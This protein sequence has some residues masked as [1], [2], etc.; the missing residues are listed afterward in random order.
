MRILLIGGGK[1]GSYLA[2]ELVEAGH[3]VSV[4]EPIAERAHEVT[5]ESKALVFEGDGT[6]VSLL[7]D[8]DVHRTDWV[9]AVTGRDEVNFVA[10]EL[11][12]QLGAKRVLA[13]LNNPRNR[14]TFDAV[15][16]P[17][18]AVTDL[19]ARVISRE[20]SLPD[21]GRIAVIGNAELSLCEIEVGAGVPDVPLSELQLPE[22]SLLVTVERDGSAWVPGRDTVLKPGDRVT[23]VTLLKNE[24]ALH[25][26]LRG[27]VPQQDD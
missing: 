22:S 6:D 14:P 3:A 4:I 15:G 12:L 18:V 1:V 2:R 9:V 7:K 25:K 17:V 8:A 23:A 24:A 19:M 26:A 16:T 5:E 20:V 10:C 21:L 27:K 11:A 13:R